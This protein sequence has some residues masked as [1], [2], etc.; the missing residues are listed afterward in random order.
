MKTIIRKINHLNPLRFCFFSKILQIFFIMFL[1]NMSGTTSWLST[2]LAA[3][4]FDTSIIGNLPEN[5]KLNSVLN[6]SQKMISNYPM[7]LAKDRLNKLLRAINNN[8][9]N[10]LN[11]LSSK[12]KSIKINNL[13]VSAYITQA[14]HKVKIDNYQFVTPAQELAL[15]QI[16][17]NKQQTII[18]DVNGIAIGGSFDLKY[19]NN[20]IDSLIIPLG[21]TAIINDNEEF[22]LTGS[23][24]NN[25]KILV[26]KN[27]DKACISANNI[28]NAD[29]GLI[30]ANNSLSLNIEATNFQPSPKSLACSSLYSLTA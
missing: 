22:Q 20:N 15:K 17:D 28:F 19:L 18:L 29:S 10:S 8:N 26:D 30:I 27:I 7:P 13:T 23:I 25:G 14:N 5:V 4:A 24:I 6:Q 3:D 21:V 1:M 12:N 2:A 16:S 11:D 9:F